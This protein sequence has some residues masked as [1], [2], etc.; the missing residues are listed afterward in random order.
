MKTGAARAAL[1]V[2][3][4]V[5]PSSGRQ[6]TKNLRQEDTHEK[7]ASRTDNCLRCNCSWST[8]VRRELDDVSPRLKTLQCEFRGLSHRQ[9]HGVHL[10]AG[11]VHVPCQC[12][13]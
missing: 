4:R 3:R 10:A 8:V 13:G 7:P 6:V 1:R 2:A 11:M 12:G 5:L 9:G